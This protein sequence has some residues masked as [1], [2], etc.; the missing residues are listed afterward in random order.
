MIFMIDTSGKCGQLYRE[1]QQLVS[2]ELIS[3]LMVID[4]MMTKYVSQRE[5]IQWVSQTSIWPMI[6]LSINN[7]K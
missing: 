2:R 5:S 6:S 4:N 7:R 1:W 3:R